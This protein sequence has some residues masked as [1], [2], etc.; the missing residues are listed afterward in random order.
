M[1][2][3][4]THLLTH[5]LTHPIISTHSLTYPPHAPSPLTPPPYQQE[6][7]HHPTDPTENTHLDPKNTTILFVP[8]RSRETVIPGTN[9]LPP[10]NIPLPTHN[11][12]FFMDDLFMPAGGVEG[13]LLWMVG[14]AIT[15][16]PITVSIWEE[17]G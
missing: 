2:H 8:K 7:P 9:R 10:D 6:T 5:S 12:I 17:E 16:T 1:K 14:V 11:P 4:I 13:V 3:P 15:P